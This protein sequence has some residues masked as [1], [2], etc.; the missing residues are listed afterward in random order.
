MLQNWFLSIH[1]KLVFLPD[2]NSY[3]IS[4]IVTSSSIEPRIHITHVANAKPM[5]C[6]IYCMIDWEG[7]L[8][9]HIVVL[10]NLILLDCATKLTVNRNILMNNRMLRTDH[11][12]GWRVR[13]YYLEAS[14]EKSLV[15]W[16]TR[17]SIPQDRRSS[18]TVDYRRVTSLQQWIVIT[19]IIKQ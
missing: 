8:H 5:R 18:S 15:S 11:G 12:S 4:E 10:Q 13:I 16:C 6:D 3:F 9:S 7:R 14:L 1:C 19:M 17:Y 2:Q